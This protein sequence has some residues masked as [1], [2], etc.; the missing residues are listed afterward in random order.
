[1]KKIL[2][3]IVT[4]SLIQLANMAPGYAQAG[5]ST[6]PNKLYYTFEPGGSGTQKLIVQNPAD[7]E[8]EV[9]ISFSD[10]QYDSLGNNITTD[11]GTLPHSCSKWITI[12]QGSYFILK[13]FERKEL[14]VIV[15]APADLNKDIPVHTA[16]LYLTQLNPWKPGQSEE[17][18]S[19]IVTVR[20][21][22][23]IYY[24]HVTAPQRSIEIVNFSHMK[25]HIEGAQDQLELK[26]DNLS[27]TWVKGNVKVELLNT[28]NGK[29]LFLDEVEFHQLPGDKRLVRLKLPAKADKG[30]YNATA[31][32][33]YGDR[34]ELKVAELDFM[35]N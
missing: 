28:S 11:P 27:D 34:D 32:V 15:T 31:I 7:K 22:V 33:N 21:G 25:S 8:L 30:K 18:A 3:F 12:A 6:S 5:V 35:L 1:M 10:W 14:D 29:K 16:M 24:S 19:I 13:P 4:F 9:G 17:G 20:M 2:I 26:I 23:K